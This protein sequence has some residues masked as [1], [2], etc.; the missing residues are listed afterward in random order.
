M[1]GD[2]VKS[3]RFKWGYIRH[4]GR[5]FVGCGTTLSKRT[6]AS[7]ARSRYLVVQVEQEDTGGPGSSYQFTALRINEEGMTLGEEIV[8][9]VEAV[10]HERI[11]IEQITS[12]GHYDKV[13]FFPN[14][15]LIVRA[16]SKEAAAKLAVN[17]VGFIPTEEPTPDGDT[18][19]IIGHSYRGVKKSDSIVGV[20]ELLT[21]ECG[22]PVDIV[23]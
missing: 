8:V 16:A 4:D 2:I 3:D 15:A 11:D 20:C 6:D 5:L 19:K 10:C 1:V 18:W 7:R 22:Q 9:E 13:P 17:L 21:A 23:T 12:F 14:A